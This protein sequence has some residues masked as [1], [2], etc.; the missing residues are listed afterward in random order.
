[1]NNNSKPKEAFYLGID[2]SKGYADFIILDEEKNIIEDSFQLDDTFE[3]HNQLHQILSDFFERH[4]D[5]TIYSAVESTG[6]YENNWFTTLHK[7]QNDLSVYVARL[8]PIGV[9][10]NSKAGLQRVI[11]DKISAKNVSEY[12]ISHKEKVSYERTDYFYSLR[13]QWKFVKLLT[14]Q[15]VQLLNQ[16]ESLVYN[17]NPEVLIYCK[18]GMPQW[19]LKLLKQYPTAKMLSKAKLSSV[20]SIPYIKKDRAEEIINN[21]KTSIA[22]AT[23]DITASLVRSTVEQIMNLG[24]VIDLQEK[25]ISDNCS[26]P[27]VEILKSFTGIGDYSAVGLVMNIGAIERFIS[28]KKLACFFGMHPVYKQSG[29]GSWGMHMSKKGRSEPRHILYNVAKCAIVHNPLI[30][31]I[32]KEHLKKGMCKMSAIGCIMHKILRIV[33]GMLKNKE[34]FNPDVDERNRE[35]IVIRKRKTTTH[36]IRRF[37][38][39]DIKAPI[40]RRQNKKRKERE[41]SQSR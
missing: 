41:L 36:K 16:L 6:G 32:Y 37:Q 17:A 20:K 18:D 8:N 33:Y 22:S 11:N 9:N 40:S 1:M 34:K 38:T 3:G 30:K 14:K 35:K 25:Q 4:P 39:E 12:L 28:S 23:D 21:A 26:F 15:R 24:K 13:K 2:V 7:F 5:S 27:E 29:D 19:V 10:H 31:E